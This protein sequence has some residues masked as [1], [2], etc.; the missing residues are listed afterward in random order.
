VKRFGFV[1]RRTVALV[2]AVGALLLTAS[3]ASAQMINPG[4]GFGHHTNAP[5]AAPT[6]DCRQPASF[7]GSPQMASTALSYF[8]PVPDFKAVTTDCTGSLTESSYAKGHVTM[9][10]LYAT[11]CPPCNAEATEEEQFYQLHQADGLVG[12]GVLTG[13]DTGNPTKWYKKYG[14]T[15]PTVWDVG[16][17]ISAAYQT[18]PEAGFI[19][20][21]VWLHADGTIAIIFYGSQSHNYET[22]DGHNINTDL[23]YNFQVNYECAL[24]TN[25]QEQSDPICL[26]QIAQNSFAA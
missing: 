13:D 12:L 11:W 1:G 18:N 4:I 16:G 15:F 10:N 14:W 20:E 7:V 8:G 26:E 23:W 9:I 6:K 19:P 17:K 25:A 24:E 5:Q 22:V 21:T 2:A 3:G